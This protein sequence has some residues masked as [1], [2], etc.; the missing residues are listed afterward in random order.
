MDMMLRIPLL[1][2]LSKI[3]H[4]TICLHFANI[5]GNITGTAF[6]IFESLK[7]KN[8]EPQQELDTN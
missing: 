2:Y 6:A 3:N 7:V 4:K 8:Q 1:F 5:I